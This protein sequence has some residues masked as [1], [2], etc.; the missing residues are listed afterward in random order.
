MIDAVDDGLDECIKTTRRLQQ[1]YG[2][3][4]F[5]LTYGSDLLVSSR[6]GSALGDALLGFEVGMSEDFFN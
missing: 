3:K 1:W 4:G 6:E 5:A 2:L